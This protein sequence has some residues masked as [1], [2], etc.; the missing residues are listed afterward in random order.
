LTRTLQPT[1]R[2]AFFACLT[3]WFLLFSAISAVSEEITQPKTSLSCDLW[4]DPQGLTHIRA[5][6]ERSAYACFGY[7]HAR[8]RAWQL[9]F[10]RR[11]AQGRKAEILG[12]E[13]IRTDFMMR[14][15][16]LYPHAQRIFSS[17]NSTHREWLEAYAQ[18]VNQGLEIAIQEGVYEFQEWNYKPEAWQAV[19]T[20]ALM[21]LQSFDQTRENF[22][23]DYD[24]FNKFKKFGKE[25]P[26]L[27]LNDGLPWDTSILKPGEFPVAT[28][29]PSTR[30][31]PPAPRAN[32][33]DVAQLRSFAEQ[34]PELTP[35]IG[36]GSNNW[37]VSSER[38]KTGH[39]WLA[40]DPHLELR[41]P[42][43]WHLIHLQSPKLNVIGAAIPGIPLIVSGTNSNVSWGLTNSY[44]KAAD[45][46]LIPEEEIE[47][48]RTQDRPVIWF[49]MGKIKLPFFFKTFER[50]IHDR[51]ILPL[52][53]P[54]GKKL[55]LNWTTYDLQAKDL[56]GLF[57]LMSANSLTEIDTA[58]S[59]IGLPSWNFVFAEK[60]GKI[61]YRAVGRTPRF[62]QKAP[63]GI[64][65]QSLADFEKRLTTETVLTPDE[66]PHV[67]NP[68]RGWVATANNRQWPAEAKYY[69]GRSHRQGWRE[70]R[71]EELLA[72]GD[73]HDFDSLRRIQCDV[74]ATDAKFLLPLLLKNT[75]EKPELSAAL[76]TLKNWDFQAGLECKACAVYRRW[77]SRIRS[78]TEL[79]LPALYRSLQSSSDEKF[80]A[81]LSDSLLEA[82][83]DLKANPNGNFPNWGDVH[84]CSFAHLST[85]PGEKIFFNNEIKTSGDEETVSPGSS[86]WE[87]GVFQQNSG[88]SQRLIVELS[89]P[90][91]VYSILPGKMRDEAER[92]LHAPDSPWSKWANCQYEKRLFPLDWSKVTPTRISLGKPEAQSQ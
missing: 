50:T 28:P 16:G 20:I 29:A 78:Q 73:K 23:T 35:P 77:I 64:R 76:T 19:D 56:D 53:A 13:E 1:L 49:K 91:A 41:H 3:L 42:S 72:N 27:F 54:K 17:L 74:Q 69:L 44:L 36:V 87:Q 34:F 11:T 57:E 47:K 75:P 68:P 92:D 18:G 63:Y 2:R 30:Q 59:R 88:A 48:Q 31:E 85:R 81:L 52:D 9:D 66:M 45:L 21:L 67:L 14:L 90:P 5:P 4:T 22:V 15:L 43:M 38:S 10:F 55:V 82:L 71:I 51:P 84:R 60:S 58:L 80:R 39:A 40:N 61:G 89:D 33:S 70:Y 46:T 83:R 25:A 7:T 26:L 12:R 32:S 86:R 62:E 24:E 6:N 65:E 8:D 79:N 37:V